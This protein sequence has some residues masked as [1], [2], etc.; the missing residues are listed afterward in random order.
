VSC[1]E[2]WADD[3]KACG[4][5]IILGVDPGMTRTG[6]GVLEV[7]PRGFRLLDAGVIA[8]SSHRPLEERLEKIFRGVCSLIDRH[9]PR[10]LVIE[11]LYSHYRHPETAILMGHVRGVICCAAAIA[12]IRVVGYS[13]TDVKKSITGSGRAGK[14]QVQRAVCHELG[15]EKVLEP[16][17]VTD[18]LALSICHVRLGSARSAGMVVDRRETW[19]GA[20]R[21]RAPRGGVPLEEAAG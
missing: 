1:S 14:D 10:V 7:L 19:R 13:A 2:G 18:A 20:R 21:T 12:G 15:L 4:E 5:S 17:D 8:T 16:A 3:A 11:K 9:A 6:Y